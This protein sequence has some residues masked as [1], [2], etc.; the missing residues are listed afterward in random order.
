MLKKFELKLSLHLPPDWSTTPK[1]ELEIVIE[2]STF[3]EKAFLLKLEEHPIYGYLIPLDIEDAG[4]EVLNIITKRYM[5]LRKTLPGENK[6]MLDHILKKQLESQQHKE[7]ELDKKLKTILN[8]EKI[9][10]YYHIK[11]AYSS[12]G[13][14]I[15]LSQKPGNLGIKMLCAGLQELY[16][17]D[18]RFFKEQIQ[19]RAEIAKKG[20]IARKDRYLE[21]KREAC[22][23]L[24]E[25]TPLKGW[26]KEL[27]AYKAILPKIKKYM[28]DNNTRYPAQNTIENTL[29]RWI[30]NDPIV[31][32]AVR[33]AQS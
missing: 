9:A 16:S 27:D 26:I 32:A 18:Q 2:Q 11:N 19:S 28:K 13:M 17:G 21:T 12:I 24:D 31:S 5:M 4:N 10:A 6:A 20:G 25:L 15:L 33:I 30:K 23:Q 29:R 7:I 1:S 3:K 14:A 22:R 8:K